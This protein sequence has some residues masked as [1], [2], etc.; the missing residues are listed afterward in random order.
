MKLSLQVF[1]IS[2]VAA[3]FWTESFLG[4]RNVLAFKKDWQIAQENF[5]NPGLNVLPSLAYRKL[6]T[7]YRL[8]TDHLMGVQRLFSKTDI[9][10][11]E[12]RGWFRLG[13]NAYVDLIVNGTPLSYTGIRL[14][15][16]NLFPSMIYEA[17]HTG[18][19]LSKK[20]VDLRLKPGFHSA[21]IKDSS[22][23]L[24]DKDVKLPPA[25][26]REGKVGAQVSIQDSDLYG[27]EARSPEKD[28][29]LHFFPEGN[30]IG[31]YLRHFLIILAI[32]FLA[33]KSRQKSNALLLAGLGFL[34]FG[35]TIVVKPQDETIEGAM[36]KFRIMDAWWKPEGP[37][38]L[39]EK[40]QRLHENQAFP[41]SVFCKND[42]CKHIHPGEVPGAKTGKR[43]VFFGGSQT[44]PALVTRP[45]QSFIY[46]FDKNI[47]TEHPDV[48]LLNVS[49]LGLF[50]E[51]LEEQKGYLEKLDMDE[52]IVE[53]LSFATELKIIKDFMKKWV[54]AGVKVYYLRPPVNP[55]RIREDLTSQVI[56]ELKAGLD[57]HGP[58]M[59]DPGS[60][61]ILRTTPFF[62][63]AKKE[64]EFEFIDPNQML[65]DEEVMH[66]GEL[67]W[68]GF[69]FTG[70]GQKLYGEWLAKEYL[71]RSK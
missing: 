23:R 37:E 49:S 39:Q 27:L 44:I 30:R 24:G 35:Y 26:M 18:K 19:Y 7:G 32:V 42:G 31:I 8:S 48:E 43:I 56:T 59:S 67:F 9:T 70:W 41:R 21:V 54:K 10:P 62:Q 17:D 14:S 65:L 45:E 53:N 36:L 38:T 55:I 13:K 58:A 11:V 25:L 66:S 71:Q 29:V 12:M 52:I 64:F 47:R 69:H 2:L 68:D 33:G 51:R 1:L 63:T 6:L 46:I 60:P 5:I 34:F 16:S 50:Q 3:I 20:P 15:S 40:Y 28:L 22:L 57:A 61:E 4:Q